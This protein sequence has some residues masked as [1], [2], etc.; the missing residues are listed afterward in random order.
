MRVKHDSSAC[1]YAGNRVVPRIMT[2]SL[3][4][5][6]GL[7]CFYKIKNAPHAVNINKKEINYH[8]YEGKTSGTGRGSQKTD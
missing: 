5:G 8:G 2:P 3:L 1:I 4:V 6:R 7:F